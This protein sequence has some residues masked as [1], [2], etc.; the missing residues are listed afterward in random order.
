[1]NPC[2][3]IGTVKGKVLDLK[4]TV[5]RCPEWVARQIASWT[6]RQLVKGET[7]RL[8]KVRGMCDHQ[9]TIAEIGSEYPTGRKLAGGDR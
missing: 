7:I 4:L 5:H 6:A 8:V 9:P 3:A 1:M 2:W